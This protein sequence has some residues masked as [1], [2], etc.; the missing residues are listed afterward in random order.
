MITSTN[1]NDFRKECAFEDPILYT[2]GTLQKNPCIEDPPFL[3]KGG[4]SCIFE[5]CHI[6]PAVKILPQK[7]P[8]V[9]VFRPTHSLDGGF[10]K[11]VFYVHPK[12]WGT[13]IQIDFRIFFQMG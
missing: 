12:P 10:L 6:H 4:R 8:V 1:L 5:V 3:F 9:Q 11:Y 2:Y 13:W 7:T